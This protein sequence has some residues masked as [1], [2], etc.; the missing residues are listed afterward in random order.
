MTFLSV[1]S[2]SEEHFPKATCFLS[3]TTPSL[4]IY[5]WPLAL[6]PTIV[7]SPACKGEVSFWGIPCDLGP[8][9]CPVSLQALDTRLQEDDLMK[10]K[11]KAMQPRA[12]PEAAVMYGLN[13]LIPVLLARL[14]QGHFASPMQVASAE[15][16][17]G[18]EPVASPVP[19]LPSGHFLSILVSQR[20]GPSFL[21]CP[22]AFSSPSPEPPPASQTRS[23]TSVPPSGSPFVLTSNTVF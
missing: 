14:N 20:E 23:L 1:I 16:E 22:S 17:P 9:F 18:L 11:I 19:G 10:Q 7:K 13:P 4:R 3:L 8:A 5:I 12:D 15:G 6:L 2:S 21:S